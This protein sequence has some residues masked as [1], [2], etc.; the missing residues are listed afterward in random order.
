MSPNSFI[1]TALCLPNSSRSPLGINSLFEFPR[2]RGHGQAFRVS[3]LHSFFCGPTSRLALPVRMLQP[4]KPS[5]P[6]NEEWLDVAERMENWA[7]ADSVRMRDAD[8]IQYVVSFLLRQSRG[9]SHNYLVKQKR[10][11]SIPDTHQECWN[12][13]IVP[14][15]IVSTEARSNALS[16]SL[17]IPSHSHP[18]S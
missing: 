5:L 16:I 12:A 1:D 18:R 10:H 2:R 17:I 3:P 4:S 6:I 9:R 13:T 7:N 14:H 11:F 8:V 15:D